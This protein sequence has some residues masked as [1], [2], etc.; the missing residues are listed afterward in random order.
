MS[1]LT[2]RMAAVLRALY[3]RQRFDGSHEQMAAREVLAE[4]DAL[5]A[6]PA[7]KPLPQ[8]GQRVRCSDEK[9][10]DLSWQGI[11]LYIQNGTVTV[12]TD[13]GGEFAAMAQEL[14]VVP[15]LPAT[16]TGD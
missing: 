14:E 8:V 4:Y 3:D 10:D 2:D 5:R 15:N 6:A 16:N 1:T 13:D 11:V 12:Q 9:P 7:A